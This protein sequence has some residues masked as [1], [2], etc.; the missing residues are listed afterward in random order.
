MTTEQLPTTPS[1][2][3][4]RGQA[5]WGAPQGRPARWSTGRTVVAAAVAVAVVAAGGAA[6]Y[7]AS[8]GSGGSSGSSA[9]GQNGAGGMMGGPGGQGG[10]GGMGGQSA[11]SGALHGEYTVSGTNGTYTTELM[12]TGTVTAVGSTSLT[13]KS[14]DGYV[15]TYT[16]D[17]NTAVGNNAN[18]SSIATGD[19]VTVVATVNG[20]TATATRVTE[21]TAGRNQQNQQRQG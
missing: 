7:A 20:G 13:A 11:L 3:D 5:H 16:I 18:S 8:S 10:Q 9:S 15:R 6:V 4:D 12:Q 21:R 1:P 19:T 2:S 14:A 17:G